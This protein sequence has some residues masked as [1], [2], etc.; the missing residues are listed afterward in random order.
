MLKL[1]IIIPLILIAVFMVST[2]SVVEAV[3][4]TTSANDS[5]DHNGVSDQQEQADYRNV[6][7][8]YSQSE[9]SVEISSYNTYNNTLTEISSEVSALNGLKI[10]F[11]YSNQTQTKSELQI[12]LIANQIVEFINSNTAIPGY[13][14]QD[15]LL[16]TYNLSSVNWALSVSNQTV[17]NDTIWL[18]DV[19]GALSS[20]STIDFTF[21]LTNGYALLSANNVLSPNALKWSVKISNYQYSA[22]NSQLALQMLMSSG[23]HNSGFSSDTIS[24]QT[25]DH[26]DGL[27]QNNESAVNFGN[28]TTDGFFSWADQYSVDGNN[29]TVVTSP[30]VSVDQENTTYNQLY[31]SFDQGKI[32]N[33]DPKVGVD[34][35][36]TS[37]YD[38]QHPYVAPS[39]TLTSSSVSSSVTSPVANNSP[40]VSLTFSGNQNKNSPGFEII[41]VMLSLGVIG[42]VSRKRFKN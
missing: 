11:S 4:S 33:W 32:I 37:L 2:Y 20:S 7:F 24:N 6:T 22:P 10:E 38:I 28:G 14:P 9:K 26:T 41:A 13:D 34:R 42:L 25:E 17:N 36:S 8:D 27:T 19:S 23:Q 35:N 29:E 1:K 12:K 16:H 30:V 21:E 5:P 3:A 40:S 31:F 39:T 15:T 18:V